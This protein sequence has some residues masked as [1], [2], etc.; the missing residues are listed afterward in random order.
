L[1]R[2]GSV[3]LPGPWFPLPRVRRTR[4]CGRCGLLYPVKARQCPHCGGLTDAEVEQLKRRTRDEQASDA[5]LGL[6]FLYVAVLLAG[7][8][9]LLVLF[10]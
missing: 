1:R 7:A 3:P 4:K 5:N 8:M 2:Y 6:L 10:A 9:V